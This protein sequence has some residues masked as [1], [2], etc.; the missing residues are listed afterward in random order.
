MKS[1]RISCQLFLYHTRRRKWSAD[2]LD[3][4]IVYGFPRS[5]VYAKIHS[6]LVIRGEHHGS[7]AMVQVLTHSLPNSIPH[8]RVDVAHIYPGIDLLQ[9][10]GQI[11]PKPGRAIRH[12]DYNDGATP[13]F[14]SA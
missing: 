2:Q 1:L 8:P 3:P 9:P 11:P 13:S 6:L 14:P 5:V 10:F 7:A 4:F 12:S